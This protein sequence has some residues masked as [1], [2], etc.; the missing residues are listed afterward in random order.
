MFTDTRV[1]FGAPTSNSRELQ[2]VHPTSLL[3]KVCSSSWLRLSRKDARWAILSSASFSFGW[4]N[5]CA[6]PG[7]Q[8]SLCANQTCMPGGKG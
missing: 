5:R 8:T 2:Q 3:L 7:P 6:L 4:R 1:S